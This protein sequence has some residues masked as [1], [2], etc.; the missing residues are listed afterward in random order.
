MA[1]DWASIANEVAGAISDVGFTAYLEQPTGRGEYPEP[2]PVTIGGDTLHSV[3]VIDSEIRRFDAG[4]GAT[5][6]ARILTMAATGPVVPAKGW[7]IRVRGQWHRIAS[8]MPLA[9][10]GTDLLFDLEIEA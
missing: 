3:T 5:R 9:P 8:V 10:G 6:T 1:E 4:N 2:D 7:R